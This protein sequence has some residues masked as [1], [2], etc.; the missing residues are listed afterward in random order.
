MKTTTVVMSNLYVSFSMLFVLVMQGCSSGRIV[1]KEIS[2]SYPVAYTFKCKPE[3]FGNLF[4]SYYFKYHND[5]NFYLTNI[6]FNEEG[7]NRIS[8]EQAKLKGLFDEKNKYDVWMMFFVDSSETFFSKTGKPMR[9][10]MECKA[11]VIPINH[12]SI[13]VEI[14]VIEAKVQTGTSIIPSPPHFQNNPIFKEVSP[15]TFDQYKILF[16]FGKGICVADK[17]PGLITN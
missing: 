8:A 15:P 13:K 11:H 7:V 5:L 10:F 1:Q 2:A 4:K 9:Y 16:C 17:M 6:T 3:N 14:Q 12:D